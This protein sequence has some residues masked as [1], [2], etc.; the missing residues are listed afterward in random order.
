[1]ILNLYANI[2][3]KEVIPGSMSNQFVM[4]KVVPQSLG[5]MS[6]I[7]FII[8]PLTFLGQE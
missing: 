4:S 3:A 2:Q 5:K 6:C 7:D 1:V 8:F